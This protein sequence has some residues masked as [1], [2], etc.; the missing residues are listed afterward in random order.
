MKLGISSWFLKLGVGGVPELASLGSLALDGG[1]AISSVSFSGVRR[2]VMGA[3]DGDSSIFIY[4]ASSHFHG[5]SH[6]K[7]PPI[8]LSRR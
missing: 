3:E 2:M 7:S 6:D 1:G 5:F 8:S 4:S